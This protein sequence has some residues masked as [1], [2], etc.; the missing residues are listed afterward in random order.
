[1]LGPETIAGWSI[2]Q[3]LGRGKSANVYEATNGDAFAAIKIFDTG[4]VE[5][6]GA[7]VQLAR[8]RRE[9]TLVGKHH[10]NLI[11]IYDGGVCETTRQLYVA[12]RLLKMPN[13][14]EVIADVPRSHIWP[15]MS[16]LASAARFLEELNLA[17]RDIKPENIV[18]NSDFSQV[19]LLDLGVMRPV[20]VA[21][22]TD[23]HQRFFI[24]T[25]RYG[26]PE[27]LM[28]QEVDS[29]EGWRALTFYQLGAV[30]SDLIM[31]RPLF[32]MPDE[33]YAR[34]VEAVLH[35]VPSIEAADVSPD[36]ILLAKN[37]LVKDPNLRLSL[38]NWDSFNPTSS[39]SFSLAALKG[40]LRQQTLRGTEGRR[41]EKEAYARE[42]TLR[43]LLSQIV[44]AM[45]GMIRDE[46]VSTELLP[47]VRIMDYPSSS[48]FCAKYSVFF[49]V[50]EEGGNL[51]IHLLISV[52]VI[53]AAAAV[54]S[55]EVTG[56]VSRYLN[57]GDVTFAPGWEVY[58]GVFQEGAIMELIR[59]ILYASVYESREIQSRQDFYDTNEYA[60]TL[61][62]ENVQP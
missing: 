20:G 34:L 54:I 23:M 10:P 37:C 58:R 6:F 50:T 60:L 17:H 9:L 42:V 18:I 31:R 47:P 13:L 29:V 62:I 40:R 41:T 35:D 28:R 4:L 59:F 36:L 24:G 32:G 43:R 57:A 1:M 27:Y 44:D 38:V 11:E 3:R 19:T 2:G 22:L 21:D 7:D 5:R 48:L 52:T 51:P 16:Q 30:L 49:G 14:A 39:D 53:D 33:P 25:L 26:A 8:V 61:K 45:H 15:I 46:C 12:M 55:V 56:A